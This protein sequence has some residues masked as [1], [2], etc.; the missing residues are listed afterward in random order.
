MRRENGTAYGGF[1]F[2]A[3]SF[4]HRAAQEHRPTGMSRS[5]TL[6]ERD[7]I[8]ID[9]KLIHKT[10]L[11]MINRKNPWLDDMRMSDIHPRCRT[12]L[13]WKTVKHMAQGR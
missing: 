9:R 1:L 10:H 5:H 4:C 8:G 2:P 12:N 7:L 11:I 3:S 6:F 13:R